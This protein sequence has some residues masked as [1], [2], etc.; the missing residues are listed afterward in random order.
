MIVR[1]PDRSDRPDLAEFRC[2]DGSKHQN[3]VEAWIRRKAWGWAKASVSNEI[4]ILDVDNVL[5]G[6]CAFEPGEDDNS[7]FIR[8]VA[9]ATPL[10]RYGYASLFLATCLDELQGRSPGGYAYWKVDKANDPSHKLSVGVGGVQD[11]A[12]PSARLVTYYVAFV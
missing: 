1:S 6:V 9:L 3:A 11:I 12:P 4:R 7:W 10:Q 2:S 5:A 8:V